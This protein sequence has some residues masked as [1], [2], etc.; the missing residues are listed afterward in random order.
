MLNIT[1]PVTNRCGHVI[2]VWQCWHVLW[3]EAAQSRAW[4]PPCSQGGDG[5][6]ALIRALIRALRQRPLCTVLKTFTDAQDIMEEA[7]FSSAVVW[8]SA[9]LPLSYLT[10]TLPLS[11]LTFILPYLYLTLPYP[12]QIIIRT[13]T[14]PAVWDEVQL[15]LNSI[16]Y[17]INVITL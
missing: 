8:L 1:L 12:N 2:S 7:D 10:F 3:W 16:L 15:N 17:T 11:Y 6:A 14:Y 5:E 4:V 9:K 13:F